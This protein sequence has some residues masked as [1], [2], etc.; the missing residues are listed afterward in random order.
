MPIPSHA[1]V[2]LPVLLEL[3]RHGGRVQKNADFPEFYERIARHF[4]DLTAE[5]LKLRRQTG[6]RPFVWHNVVEWT[7]N[8]LREGGE[9]NGGQR[10][11]WEITR[12]GKDRLQ[13]ELASIG[14]A[15]VDE[16]IHSNRLIPEEIGNRWRPASKRT[17]VQRVE[18]RATDQTSGGP[19]MPTAPPLTVDPSHSTPPGSAR[20]GEAEST[21]KHDLLSR[22][23]SLDP[24]QFEYLIA[25]FLK[26]TGMSEVLVTGTMGDGGID[27]ECTIPFLQIKCAFQAKRYAPTNAVGSPAMRNF[28]GGVVGRYDRGI[29]ITTSN[30]SS[31]AIEEAGQ[32]GVTIITINGDQ[33]VDLLIDKG[34]GIKTIPVVRHDL[35]EEFFDKLQHS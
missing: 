8:S 1:S 10:G 13:H 31:G 33:L 35:D 4:P 24:G 14:I 34:L 32:P 16:F 23:Q 27:G 19:T 22:L 18:R 29:F 2:E 7:R 30:F 9:L 12:K 28:K 15:S 25:E 6:G 17:P 20:N 5:D 11:V 26:A 3:E 21:I